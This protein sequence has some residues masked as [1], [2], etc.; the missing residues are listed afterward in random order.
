MSYLFVLRSPPDIDH[1]TPLAWKLLE[2]GDEVHAV[3][4]SGYDPAPD[5]RLELLRRYPRFRQHALSPAAGEGL[6]RR[7]W[8]RVR[9]YGMGTLPFALVLLRR[10]GIRLTAI[11]WGSGLRSAYERPRSLAWALAIL[12]SLL[13]SFLKAADPEQARVNFLVASQLLGVPTVCLPHGLNIKLDAALNEEEAARLER[14]PIDWRDRNRVAAYVLNTEHHRRWHIENAMGDPEVMQAWGSLR[15]APEWFEL[16]RALAPPF[17]WPDRSDGRL[18]VLFMTP[19]WANRA[20]PDKARELLRRVRAL[21]FVSVGLMGHPR[22]GQGGADDL[23]P[24]H[25]AGLGKVHDLSG[26]SSVGVIQ[27]CDV[28]ID[29][30]SSIGIEAVMQGKVLVNPTYIHDLTTIFDEVEGSC[31]VAHGPD[32]VIEYLHRHA[33]GSPHRVGEVAY[34]ELLRWAVYAS[35]TEPYDVIGTYARRV[36]ALAGAHALPEAAPAPGPA[37]PERE[38]ARA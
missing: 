5:H 17:D 24:D 10:G 22:P 6:L 28:M 27:A 20:H 36:R 37:A 12:R 30:S 8:S 4:S 13:R 21:D 2:E 19:R 11:E 18:K 34:A 35:A 33:N 9:A 15:W 31:V 38:M 23:R 1:M 7:A 29:V 3:I 26:G 16:N 14:G 32:E 25:E